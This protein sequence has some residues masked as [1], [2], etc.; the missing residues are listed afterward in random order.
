[1]C[2]DTSVDDRYNQP[3]V[4]ES[5]GGVTSTT[6]TATATSE[7]EPESDGSGNSSSGSNTA[8][9]IAGGVVGGVA[10]L[11]IICA[12]LW[13]FIRRQSQKHKGM[14]VTEAPMVQSS[15]NQFPTQ[16]NELDGQPMAELSSNQPVHELPGHSITK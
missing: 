12:L 3:G 11:A 5:T 9:P 2:Y 6:A 13:Y 1:M 8:G 7:P 15:P 10:G 4:A 16:P 14:P